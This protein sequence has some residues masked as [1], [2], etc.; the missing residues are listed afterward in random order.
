MNTR[1]ISTLLQQNNITKQ[2]FENVYALDQLQRKRKIN[3]ERWFLICNCCLKNLPGLHWVVIFRDGDN[4]DFFYSFGG[5]PT[6]YGM[7][8]F[9]KR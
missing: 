2:Y 8:R 9:I 4:I 7:E 3:K 1:Q 6:E 5:S